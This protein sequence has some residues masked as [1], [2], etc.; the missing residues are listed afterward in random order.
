MG[1][2]RQVPAGKVV[3]AK[4][5][6]TY[7]KKKYNAEAIEIEY[8][9]SAIEMLNLTFPFWRE[10]SANGYLYATTRFRSRD[11]QQQLLE[12]EGLEIVPCGANRASLK[13]KD[14]KEHLFD[15]SALLN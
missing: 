6:D 7:F 5:I 11:Q 14:Y 9:G 15:L 3:T 10:L 1:L 4:T 13:V 2:M 8:M 12:Q